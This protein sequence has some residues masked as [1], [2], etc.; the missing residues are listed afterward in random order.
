MRSS[1]SGRD[2][3]DARRMPTSVAPRRFAWWPR[4]RLAWA[5]GREGDPDGSARMSPLPRG[6]QVPGMPQSSAGGVADAG[7][8]SPEGLPALQGRV[9]AP[10]VGPGWHAYVLAGGD[11][12]GQLGWACHD[13]MNSAGLRPNHRGCRTTPMMRCTTPWT[14]VTTPTALSLEMLP[15]AKDSTKHH[16]H[17]DDRQHN[18]EREKG[19]LLTH[20]F[21]G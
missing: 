9:P 7:C 16:K 14:R 3:Q 5:F 15:V 6:K 20:G 17:A 10:A 4:R 18:H 8:A 13:A 21:P 19:Y 2:G 1:P 11:A 12:R